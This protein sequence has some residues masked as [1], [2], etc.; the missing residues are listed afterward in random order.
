LEDVEKKSYGKAVKDLSDSQEELT[1]LNKQ[2]VNA[3]DSRD[4]E[5]NFGRIDFIKACSD[6]VSA[7][8]KK[9]EEQKVLINSRQRSV[10]DQRVRLVDAIKQRKIFERIRERRLN[11]FKKEQR[12]L[13]TKN[14]DDIVSTRLKTKK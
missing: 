5:L 9:T 13:E 3:Y 8:R 12:K 6:Y 10:E 14:F 1:L 7:T 2:I 11:E 4:E